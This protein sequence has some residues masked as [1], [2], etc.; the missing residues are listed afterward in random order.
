MTIRR[1]V[2]EGKPTVVADPEGRI[3]QNYR[4]IARRTAAKLSM[5][6]K[7]FTAAFPNIVIDN[8]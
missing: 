5:K 3:A 7:D 2:D 8:S 6:K 1:D 4:E